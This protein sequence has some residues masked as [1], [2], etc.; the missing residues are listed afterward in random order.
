MSSLSLSGSVSLSRNVLVAE[1]SMACPISRFNHQIWQAKHSSCATSDYLNVKSLSVRLLLWLWMLTSNSFF[2]EILGGPEQLPMQKLIARTTT[3]AT[4]AA[5]AMGVEVPLGG[6]DSCAAE[7][8]RF[9]WG[10]SPSCSHPMVVSKSPES[11]KTRTLQNLPKSIRSRI[12]KTIFQ[13]Y[14][15]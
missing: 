11:G 15:T 4:S 8:Y 13:P 3:I 14:P 10:H 6:L 5:L 2:M 7:M 12:I 1:Y 9:C